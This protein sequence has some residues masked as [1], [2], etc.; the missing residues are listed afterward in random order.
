[1]SSTSTVTLPLA[2][3][4][5]SLTVGH[6]HPSFHSIGNELMFLHSISDKFLI[7]DGVSDNTH[8]Q[9]VVFVKH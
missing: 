5:F 1:M 4:Y 3:A 2:D 7:Q 6:R 8:I 9:Q